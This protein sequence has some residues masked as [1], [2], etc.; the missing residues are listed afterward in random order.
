MNFWGINVD[1]FSHLGSVILP[2]S[3]VVVF[4]VENIQVPKR[5]FSNIE[6]ISH[7]PLMELFYIHYSFLLQNWNQEVIRYSLPD[8]FLYKLSSFLKTCFS[9]LIQLLTDD[10]VLIDTFSHL[11]F[12]S[13]LEL[14]P[15]CFFPWSV[16]PHFH[17]L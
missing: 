2:S 10:F 5:I 16:Y 6:Q 13:H 7:F 3:L 12:N 17:S 9:N 11:L 4:I 8:S 1:E 15:P 14:W